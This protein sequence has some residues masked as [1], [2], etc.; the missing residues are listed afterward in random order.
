LHA[1]GK[2]FRT[3][4]ATPRTAKSLPCKFAQTHGKYAV[5][6]LVVAVQALSC[7]V[8]RQRLCRA[9]RP[10]CRATCPHGKVTHSGSDLVSNVEIGISAKPRFTISFGDLDM[11]VFF[12]KERFIT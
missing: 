1:H 12:D 3:A 9:D 10:L 6:G 11:I 5:V 2:E 4:E 8:A 7:G